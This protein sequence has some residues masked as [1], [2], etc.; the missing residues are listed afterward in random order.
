LVRA[1]AQYWR[2]TRHLLPFSPRTSAAFFSP[3][4]CF[5]DAR[6]YIPDVAARRG[7]DAGAGF[8]VLDGIGQI[9][10]SVDRSLYEAYEQLARERVSPR[11][12]DDWPVAAV[13]LLL[14]F[15]IWTEDQEIRIFSALG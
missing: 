11:D 15:P 3:D 14:G 4:I 2:R 8:Q 9:V 7:I 1:S 5:Q 6:E 10:E 13:S 12:P